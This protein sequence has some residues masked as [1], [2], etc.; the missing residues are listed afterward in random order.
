MERS[1]AVLVDME[2]SAGP[3]APPPERLDLRSSSALR[4]Q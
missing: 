1:L 4:P 2:R 3:A